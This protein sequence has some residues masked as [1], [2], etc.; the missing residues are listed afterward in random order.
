MRNLRCWISWAT[1]FSLVCACAPFQEFRDQIDAAATTEAERYPWAVSPISEESKSAI[2]EA[3]ALPGDDPFCQ[4]GK[5]VDHWDVYQKIQDVF[6]VRETT[7]SE[8][9]AVLGG[10]PHLKVETHHPN[11]T[12]VGLRYA[13]Q[14]TEYEGACIY[15]QVDTS[16]QSTIIQISASK[17]G[18]GSGPVRTKCGPSDT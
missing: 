18:S 9:E 6:P 13:Y 3:L 17:L 16:D 14:L 10:F 11:G 12:L 7:Y 8:V 1:V 15:F 4:P 2:C 5:P